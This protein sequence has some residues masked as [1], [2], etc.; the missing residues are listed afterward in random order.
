MRKDWAPLTREKL[1]EVI[2][3]TCKAPHLV[4]VLR[5]IRDHGL[6]VMILPQTSQPFLQPMKEMGE[7][8]VA[9]IA[10]DTDRAV[11]PGHYHHDSLRRLATV[12]DSAAVVASAPPPEAYAAM[13]MVPVLYDVNTAIIETR[14]EQEIQWVNF[15]HGVQ[16][17]LPMIIATV[18]G[19]QA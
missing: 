3:R 5:A 6:R 7:P 12:I 2:A 17:D 15:L 1:D 9:T 4:T 16:A 11:G 18:A 8:F 10:D 19:G 13:T 14:P